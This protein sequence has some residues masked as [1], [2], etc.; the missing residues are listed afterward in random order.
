MRKSEAKT[1]AEVLVEKFHRDY[2][3]EGARTIVQV[4][5]GGSQRSAAKRTAL[6]APTLIGAALLGLSAAARVRLTPVRRGAVYTPCGSMQAEAALKETGGHIGK[7]LNL[8]KY[9]AKPIGASPLFS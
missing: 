4:R 2:P 1:Q 5:P 7:A 3:G 6:V 9:K 8:L